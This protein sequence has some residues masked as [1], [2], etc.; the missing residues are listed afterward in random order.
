[1]PRPPPPRSVEDGTF[2]ELYGVVWGVHGDALCVHL[3]VGP[4][5]DVAG[6]GVE[7]DGLFVDG[8]CGF[9]VGVVQG[10]VAAR[11]NLHTHTHTHTHMHIHM[12]I[13]IHTLLTNICIYIIRYTRYV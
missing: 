1:M 12:Y 9:E 4:E 10:D 3:S 5:Y 7:V 2:S 11:D 13:Y 8:A 6:G